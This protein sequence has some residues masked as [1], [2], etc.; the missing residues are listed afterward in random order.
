LLQ[1][2]VEDGKRGRVIS[3]F[4]MAYFGTTPF[5]SLAAGAISTRIGAPA[6]MA[7][8]GVLCLAGAAWFASRLRLLNRELLPML[9]TANA[10]HAPARTG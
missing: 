10:R 8:S 3:F 7:M 9:A 4:L 5:G 2:V 6:T 1:T